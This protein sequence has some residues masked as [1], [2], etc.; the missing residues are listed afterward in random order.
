MFAEQAVSFDCEG[1]QLNGILH[2]GIATVTAKTGVLI[3]VGGPQYRV[4]SHRQ[5]VHLARNLAS[6]GIPVMRFD[7]TGMGDSDG[8][9]RAFDQLHKD[10]HSAIDT[11]MTLLPG[12]D[13]LVL[14]GL[15]DGASAA[16]MYAPCDQR[17]Q[18]LV[19]LNP[20]LENDEAKAKTQL[21]DYYLKRLLSGSFWSKFLSGGLDIKGSTR[22][23]GS[24]LKTVTTSHDVADTERAPPSGQVLYQQRMLEAFKTLQVPLCFILSGNDL[25]AKEFERQYFG[26]KQWKKAARN[27]EIYVKR[28]T[29]ADHTFSSSVWKNWLAQTTSS[30]LDEVKP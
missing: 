23:L 19:L 21:F 8:E 18:C 1:K 27:K 30:F 22:E 10:I 20:W 3:V 9:K 4:G 16:L 7:V 12:L 14:W 24:T 5:F 25:T 15:C 28:L 11:F 29:D 17:V 26:D 2:P 13:S 6:Q